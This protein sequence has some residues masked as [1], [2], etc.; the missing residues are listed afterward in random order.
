MAR[1][2]FPWCKEDDET[3]FF[4]AIYLKILKWMLSF[5]ILL[6]GR[7]RMLLR[8]KWSIFSWYVLLLSHFA[9]MRY[10]LLMTKNI[11]KN[12]ANNDIC[13]FSKLKNIAYLSFI[14]AITKFALNCISIIHN[15]KMFTWILKEPNHF[16]WFW[17]QEI[18]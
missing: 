13:Q 4:L 1:C 17:K 10:F 6:V 11:S 12:N 9:T 2:Q 5:K 7:I 8:H 18:F 14:R 3:S 15:N 16:V